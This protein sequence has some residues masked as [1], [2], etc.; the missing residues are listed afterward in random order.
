MHFFGTFFCLWVPF[1]FFRHERRRGWPF[2]IAVSHKKIEKKRQQQ[3]EG[4]YR[5]DTK[6]R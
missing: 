4:M 2:F 5:G 1:S 6:P 3:R